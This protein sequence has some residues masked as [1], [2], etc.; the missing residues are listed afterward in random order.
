MFSNVAVGG[1]FRT[2]GSR[3]L[4]LPPN[5]HSAGGG[6][7]QTHLATFDRDD[8]QLDVETRHHYLLTN[9]ATQDEHVT[10]SRK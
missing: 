6:N 1:G 10:F 3:R 8:G 2:L 4:L 5:G 7:S 9:T